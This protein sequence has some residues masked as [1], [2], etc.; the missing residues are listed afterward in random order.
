MLKAREAGETLSKLLNKFYEWLTE[1]GQRRMVKCKKIT[2]MTGSGSQPLLST[3][4]KDLV[5]ATRKMQP[6]NFWLNA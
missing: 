5:H 3:S 4:L 2:K 1:Q 6:Q